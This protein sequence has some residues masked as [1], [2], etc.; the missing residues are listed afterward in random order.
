MAADEDLEKEEIVPIEKRKSAPPDE[1]IKV[2]G[3]DDVMMRMAKCCNPVPGEE[4]IGYITRGRG[5]TVHRVSCRNLGKGDLERKIE[6]QW[7]SGKDQTYPVDIKVV[8]SGDRGMLATLSGVLG[9]LDA[10][11][12]G[13]QPGPRANDLNVCR[14]TIEVKDTN[15]LSRVLS[16]LRAEKGVYQVQR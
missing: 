13:I 12:I 3:V 10:K 4:I 15:H 7:D 2:R 5:I 14:L 11:I 16:T 1:G 9:Q 6:V 8:Y